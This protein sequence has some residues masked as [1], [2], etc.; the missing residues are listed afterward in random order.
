[1]ETVANFIFLGSKITADSDCSHEIKRCVL[2]GWKA[3]SS[4]VKQSPIRGRGA[5]MGQSLG[6]SAVG[7]PTD[8]THWVVNQVTDTLS[9]DVTGTI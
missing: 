8:V 9:T 5:L 7:G 4:R 3:L 6:L 1:M 2:P